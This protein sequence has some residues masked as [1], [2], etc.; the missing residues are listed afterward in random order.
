MSAVRSMRRPPLQ[1]FGKRVTLRPLK[2]GDFDQWHEVR[3]RCSAWLLPWEPRQRGAP[4]P[5]EDRPNFAHRCDIRER[6]RH[7]GIGYGFGIFVGERF[8]GEVTLSSIQRGPYQCGS[9][10]YWIDQSMAG[11]SL[12]PEAVVVTLRFAFEAISLHRVE[13]SII[14]RNMASRRVVDK[15]GIRQEGVAERFL[16]I[17]GVWED[18][19]RYAITSEEWST[20]KLDAG[21]HVASRM[22][23]SVMRIGIMDMTVNRGTLS[24]V[25]LALQEA[26]DLGASSFWVP[27]FFGFDALTTLAVVA[28]DVPDIALGTAVVPILGRTATVLAQQ[29]RTV[30]AALGGRLTLGV[31]LSHQALVEG[32]GET[33]PASPARYF[34]T[35]LARA[36]GPVRSDRCN[37]RPASIGSPHRDQLAV[38]GS[39]CL[40]RAQ[41]ARSRRASLRWCGPVV[42]RTRDAFAVHRAPSLRRR[43]G[44]GSSCSESRRW[45]AR[46]CHGRPGLGSRS[47][48]PTF[49]AVRSTPLLSLVTGP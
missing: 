6:E 12:V 43:G 33:W 42:H 20:R 39:G 47:H 16:E 3:T 15:L 9:I 5:L 23:S 18:H 22:R 28:A 25:R 7:L 13:I 35:Y 41:N 44:G 32:V 29:A 4:A 40:A 48:R 2:E 34:S 19:A 27:N 17:D 49:R 24:D 46:L 38:V 30:H 1:L 36:H 45:R 8:G 14:P 37:G 26:A 10:G 31:G 21:S 11:R